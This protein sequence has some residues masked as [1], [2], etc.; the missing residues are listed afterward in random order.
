MCS[1]LFIPVVFLAL[2]GVSAG[3]EDVP[4]LIRKLKDEDR[5][6]RT[7]AA[8]ALADIGP[9]AREAIPALIDALGDSW[10]RVTAPTFSRPASSRFDAPH[11]RTWHKEGTNLAQTRHT[12]PTR[13]KPES[14]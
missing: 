10:P 13:E 4:A 9:G 14:S 8:E 1:R 12:P 11:R 2:C 7:N 3:E 5:Q 6:V